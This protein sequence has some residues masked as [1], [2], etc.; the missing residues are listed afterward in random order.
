MRWW[1]VA[2]DAVRATGRAKLGVR[3]AAVV[4][5]TMGSLSMLP[6]CTVPESTVPTP[7]ATADD[8]HLPQAVLA[9]GGALRLHLASLVDGGLLVSSFGRR[10]HPMG[11]SGGYHR[12]L[13]IAAPSGTPVRAA[14]S[15]EVV[16]AGWSGDF[17]L[18]IRIRHSAE[19]ETVYAHLSRPAPHLRTGR[20]VRQDEIIGDVGATGNASGPHLHFEVRRNGRARDPLAL[21]PLPYGG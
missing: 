17:G 8:P 14:A 11:G 6:G 21:P 20:Q 5:C 9:D 2:T 13:D 10:R 15:G 16:E 19:I 18:M 1:K 3:A 7:P 12:G 4:I